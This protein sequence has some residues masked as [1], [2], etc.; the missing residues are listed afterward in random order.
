MATDTL[1]PTRRIEKERKPSGGLF[2]AFWRWH[3]YAAFIVAPILLVLAT[4]GLIYLLRFQIEPLMHAD[5]MKVEQPVGATQYVSYDDQRA[6][7]AKAYPK[8]TIASMT[9]PKGVDGSTDFYLSMPDGSSRDAYVDPWTGEVL[10][11]LNPDTTLSGMAVRLHANMMLGAKGD[12]LM[13]L[14]ACWAI[15]MA[16]TGYYLFIRGRA[17]RL[18]RKIAGAAGSAMRSRHAVIGSVVGVS[19]LILLVSGLPWTGF[20]GKHAQTMATDH[21]TSM[22]GSDPGGVSK[23]GSTLDESLPHSHVHE[24]PWAQGDSTVPEST[25]AGDEVSVANIDTAVAVA[26]RAGLHH[27]L[28]IALPGDDKGV[29]SA[30]SYAFHDPSREKTVHINQYDGQVVG[31]YGFDDYPVLAKVVSQGIGLHEGRSFGN[32]SFWAAALS[33]LMV[34][35]MCVSGPMMWWRRRPKKA[36]SLAAPRGR[37]PMRGTPLLAVVIVALGVFLPFFGITLLVALLLDQLI[38]RRIPRLQTWFNVV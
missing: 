3:F 24:I 14:G 38:L 13:E 8:A 10:G 35:F 30:I 33:C 28:T 27:P 5:V 4:T 36:G 12:I 1:T 16:L 20:W 25:K 37:M 18:R 26:D 19:L 11:S 15:V 7:V 29:F 6:A 9:E 23:K 31:T 34:I 22:W 21:S 32:V 17:A 2:R